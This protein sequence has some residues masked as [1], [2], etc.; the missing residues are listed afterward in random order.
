M[1]ELNNTTWKVWDFKGNGGSWGRRHPSDWRFYR[2]RIEAG[3]FLWGAYQP[4]NNIEY[5]IDLVFKES[6]ESEVYKLYLVTADHFIVVIGN[7]IK[8]MGFR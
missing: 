8:M 4:I 6:G 7:D 1:S 2:A 5:H 3:D